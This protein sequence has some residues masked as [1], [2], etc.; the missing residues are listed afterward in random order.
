MEEEAIGVVD[1]T[2]V[3]AIGIEITIAPITMVDG[4]ILLT[5]IQAQAT[6]IQTPTTTTTEIQDSTST[7]DFKLTGT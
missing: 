5:I 4:D 6:T 1:T 7:T 2:G 3:D